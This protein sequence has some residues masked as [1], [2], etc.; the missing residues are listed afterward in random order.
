MSYKVLAIFNNN[1]VISAS[2]FQAFAGFTVAH[3]GEYIKTSAITSYYRR[4]PTHID[5]TLRPLS[6]QVIAHHHIH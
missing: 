5:A 2:E 1:Q 3:H 6:R 4:L